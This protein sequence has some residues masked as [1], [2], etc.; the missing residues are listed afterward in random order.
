M[1]E[2]L[3]IYRHQWTDDFWNGRL[4]AERSLLARERLGRRRGG[5]MRATA[6]AQLMGGWAATSLLVAIPEVKDVEP[7]AVWGNKVRAVF[8]CWK[9]PSGAVR[10][11]VPLVG[12]CALPCP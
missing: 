5:R 1:Q 7:H 6:P 3:P 2:V 10:L 4:T 9:C 12:L 11:R 8:G